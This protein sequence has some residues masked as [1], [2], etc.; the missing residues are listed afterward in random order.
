LWHL[1]IAKQ[2]FSRSSLATPTMPETLSLACSPWPGQHTHGW[3]VHVRLLVGCM[4]AMPGKPSSFRFLFVRVFLAL[5][6]AQDWLAS[7]LRFDTICAHFFQVPWYKCVRSPGFGEL[8]I[9]YCIDLDQ[10]KK[11]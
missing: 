10:K 8:D 2:R 11:Y 1:R 9:V 3:Y 7:D 4:Q 6:R 5:P